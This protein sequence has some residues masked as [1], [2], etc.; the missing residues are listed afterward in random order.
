MTDGEPGL[1]KELNVA[2]LGMGLMGS[3]MALALQGQCKQVAGIDPDPAVVEHVRQSHLTEACDTV[4]GELLAQADLII[5]AAPVKTIIHLIQTLPDLHPK[6]ALLIDLGSTKTEILKAM[7]LLPE[8]F[9]PIGGHPM[10]G[11]EKLG[12]SQADADLFRNAPFVLAPLARTSPQAREMAEHLVQ[13][14]GAKAL[15]LD[16]VTHDHWVACTSHLPYLLSNALAQV[17]PLEAAPLASTGWQST[18]RLAHTSTS[19]MMD[20]LDTNRANILHALHRFQAQLAEI[21][22]LLRTENQAE[23]KQKLD[24]GT[25]QYLNILS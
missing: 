2:I 1:F 21:E 6:P 12:P 19:M 20:I 10:C 22:T 5:L 4:P 11:K 9:D 8:R 14:I 24:Q 3:S 13:F 23:L 15:W 7:Q 16:G 25:D 17:T 18:S